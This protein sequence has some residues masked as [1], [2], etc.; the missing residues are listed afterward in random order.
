QPI[1]LQNKPNFPHAQMNVTAVNTMNNELRTM[2]YF[3]QNKPNQTQF[4]RQKLRAPEPQ[5]LQTLSISLIPF[6]PLPRQAIF[7]E[8]NY[9][10]L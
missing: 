3:V 2:N 5:N 9:T 7:L 10:Y 8:Q 4:Q 6:Y 1:F